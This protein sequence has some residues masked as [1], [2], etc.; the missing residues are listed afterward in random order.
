MLAALVA[1]GC[2]KFPSREVVD[3]EVERGVAAD[4]G[5]ARRSILSGLVTKLQAPSSASE[6]D[7]AR[8][9][10]ERVA[11]LLDR[12]GDVAVL[13]ALDRVRLDGGFA[14]DMC[15][16]YRRLLLKEEARQWYRARGDAALRRCVGLRSLHWKRSGNHWHR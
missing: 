8:Y 7:V 11:Q 1:A 15:E 3:R 14:N 12:T 13:G 16:V 4:A 5:D 6:D 9:G 2:E 10:V